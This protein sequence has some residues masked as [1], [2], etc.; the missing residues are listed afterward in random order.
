MHVAVL[1]GGVSAER[2]VSLSSGA[3][4]EKA[5]LALGHSVVAIDVSAH[6]AED[7]QRAKPD[8]A[9][10]ALHGR[11]GEDGCMQGLLEILQIPYTH[12]GVLASAVAMDKPMA[13]VIFE[14]AGLRVAKGLVAHKDALMGRDVMPRP[15]VVKPANEG[16]SVGVKLV[17]ANDN[18][19]FT[20]E[21]WPYGETVLVEQYI[22]GRE[23]TCA[24]LDE[25]P[26]GVTEIT[27]AS[28][29]YDYDHKYTAGGSLHICPAQLP[30]AVYDAVMAM[31][32]TA[33]RALGCRSLTRSDFR[34]NEAGDGEIYILET[35]T[36][37]GMTPTS[38]SPELAALAGIDFNGLVARILATAR[39]DG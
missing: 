31:A 19:S 1:K 5:L 23:L 32:L 12:S 21:N 30:K 9:F 33:H 18:F 20:K 35:N 34:W 24:V 11:F 29:F 3:A 8:V 14:K 16:S 28:G 39:R 37:P 38:L 2:E 15:Y 27:T 4:V 10:N 7:L 25:A 6:V 36:Q 13:R 17:F 22:P 26:L